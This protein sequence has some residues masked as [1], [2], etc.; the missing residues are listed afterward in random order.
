MKVKEAFIPRDNPAKI[1]SIIEDF[2][3]EELNTQ[4]FIDEEIYQELNRNGCNYHVNSPNCSSGFHYG[5]DSVRFLELH[6]GNWM[7]K[8]LAL[9]SFVCNCQ[10][11]M[12]LVS[13][14]ASKV[15]K[16]THYCV[17]FKQLLLI[18]FES[19]S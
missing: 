15:K 5:D 9:G 12:Q 10:K 4:V 2:L 18:H 13:F 11:Y 14:N 7:S 19:D 6:E 3:S 8:S 17:G 1:F 16:Y